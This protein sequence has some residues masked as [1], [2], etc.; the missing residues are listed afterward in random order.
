MKPLPF[1]PGALQSVKIAAAD[2]ARETPLDDGP[3]PLLLI[4]AR[5]PGIDLAGWAAAQRA[6]LEDKL[7]RHG[8]LLFRGFALEHAAAFGAA[9][10]AIAPALLDYIE[11]AASRDEV[12]P[13]VFTSTELASDQRIPLHHEMSY[14]HNWPGRIFFYCD[15]PAEWGGQTPYAAERRFFPTLPHAIARR[16]IEHGVMYVRHFGEGVD[17]SWQAAFQ[18]TR[19]EEVED[20]C[21]ASNTAWEWRDGDRLTTR[22]VRQAIARHPVTGETVWFNHAHLFHESNLPADLRAMLQASLGPANLPRNAYYGDG[23]PIE[24]AVLDEIRG[25]YDACAGAF[26]WQRGDMLLLDNFL[27]VHGRHAYRGARRVLVAMADLYVGGAVHA[28]R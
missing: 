8:G 10:A 24:D 16:F 3:H 19:R 13:K 27:M 22:Q 5:R 15:Q 21:R 18:T 14:S 11:R 20:Y 23:S 9:A 4:E 6:A 7:L 17:L 1:A 12:A 26:D 2:L 28:E 25:R